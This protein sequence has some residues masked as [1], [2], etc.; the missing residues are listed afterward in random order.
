MSGGELRR[1]SHQVIANQSA[2]AGDPG[3]E[4]T[5]FTHFESKFESVRGR[6]NCKIG[7]EV[8]KPVGAWSG[9]R[10]REPTG[11]SSIVNRSADFSLFD[12]ASEIA[13]PT[14]RAKARTTSGNVLKLFKDV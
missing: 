7:G 10:N 11:T 5:H 1:R 6:R 2:S 3:D 4:M 12:S 8:A 9:E 14:K 13:S